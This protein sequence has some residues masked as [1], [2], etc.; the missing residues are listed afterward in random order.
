MKLKPTAIPE[1]IEIEPRVFPDDRGFFLESWN[2]KTFSDNGLDLRFVQD[3]HT[4]SVRDSLRGLSYQLERPQG[5]LVRVVAGSVFDV[6]VD[7]RHG[8]ASFGRAVS[9]ELSADRHNMLWIPAGFAHGYL[10]TS[11]R[12][13]LLYSCTDLYHPADERTL[14]WS[15][16]ALGIDWPLA[17]VEPLVSDKDA[18][19]KLLA[20]AET[21]P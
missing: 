11:D 7:L 2:Q 12:A 1:V 21:Y 13:V 18:A 14:L 15:D 10:V 20:D 5:K 4:E 17:G 16:P 8:S 3:N 6:A 9:V 19:G